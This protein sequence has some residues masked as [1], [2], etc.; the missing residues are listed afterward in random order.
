MV[1]IRFHLPKPH[2]TPYDN[3]TKYFF[4][5][6]VSALTIVIR[7][8]VDF[9][10]RVIVIGWIPFGLV[11][12]AMDFGVIR[13]LRDS[14]LPYATEFFSYLELNAVFLHNFWW[15]QP[16]LPCFRFQY[17]IKNSKKQEDQDKGFTFNAGGLRRVF[18]NRHGGTIRRAGWFAFT[19]T[20]SRGKW[21]I[22][23]LD[24]CN[25]SSHSLSPASLFLTSPSHTSP[26]P[27]LDV[28]KS[29]VSRPKVPS[30]HTRVP[31]SPSHFYTQP[32]ATNILQM[33]CTARTRMSICAYEQWYRC[34]GKFWVR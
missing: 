27:I 6:G 7:V 24:F 3:Y 8:R 15:L 1:N 11:V 4:I 21:R 13:A 33:C 28:L 16:T 19:K 23:L 30:P 25:N 14:K 20:Y 18:V 31:M 2:W 12:Q 5:L 34:D 29:L 32:H 10:C 9:H 17:S 26:R 22:Y